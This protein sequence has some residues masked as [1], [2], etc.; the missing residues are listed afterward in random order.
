MIIRWFRNGNISEVI[1]LT[2]HCSCKKYIKYDE[3]G[4]I[5]EEGEKIDK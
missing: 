5:V 3:N 1:Q 2:D 4:I